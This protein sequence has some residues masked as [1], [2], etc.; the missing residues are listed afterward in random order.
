[1]GIRV[2]KM[3]NFGKY[4]KRIKNSN[5]NLYSITEGVIVGIIKRTQS[6]KDKNS[7]G[8][9]PYSKSY[10]KTGRV[11]LTDKGS[12]LQ[13]ITRKKIKDGVRLYFGSSNENS[14]AYGNQVTYKR[15]FFGIDKKQMK[16]IKERLG[17]FIVKTTK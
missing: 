8:F 7:K 3:P 15:K 12:M 14:K 16:H 11:N 17:N 13:S 2:K 1:M 6:G 5:S 9:K 4:T 10:G